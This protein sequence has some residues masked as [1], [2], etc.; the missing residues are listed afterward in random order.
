LIISTTTLFTYQ[1]LPMW[2]YEVVHNTVVAVFL[3]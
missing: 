2:P 1:S 3:M